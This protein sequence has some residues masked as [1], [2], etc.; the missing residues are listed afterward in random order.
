MNK[1]ELLDILEMFA[2]NPKQAEK[3]S[4]YWKAVGANEVLAQ[5]MVY[6]NSYDWYRKERGDEYDCNL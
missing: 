2:R 6:L 4:E 5:I 1:Q 3:N